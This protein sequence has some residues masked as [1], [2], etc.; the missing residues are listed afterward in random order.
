MKSEK[1]LKVAD[2]T[3]MPIGRNHLDGPKNGADFRD[4]HLI[5]AL[6]KYDVVYVDFNDTL[7]TTPSFLEEVF[8]GLIRKK[9]MT[10]AELNARVFVL[11]K[12]ES[13]KNNVKK[14]IKEASDSL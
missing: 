10:A 13:V 8:G 4:N 14:Y 3:D 1:I 11:Y 7:G 2:Y 6:N 12:F 5:P 9:Y